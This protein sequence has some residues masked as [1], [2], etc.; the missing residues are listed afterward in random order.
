MT[1]EEILTWAYRIEHARRFS[2]DRPVQARPDLYE[3]HRVILTAMRIARRDV[4]WV[5]CTGTPTAPELAE[6]LLAEAVAERQSHLGKIAAAMLEE[7][8]NRAALGASL[9][10]DL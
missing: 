8:N 2:S 5:H 10:E 6:K 9:L 3:A 4:G 7:L 1:D